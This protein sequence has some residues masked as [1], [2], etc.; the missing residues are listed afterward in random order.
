MTGPEL[1][2]GNR[3][4]ADGRTPVVVLGWVLVGLVLAAAVLFGA[5]GEIPL[6]FGGVRADVRSLFTG[7]VLAVSGAILLLAPPHR[8]PGPLWLLVGLAFP[9]WLTFQLVPWPAGLTA[10]LSPERAAWAERFVAGPL[11]GCAGP[12]LGDGTAATVPLS[13]DPFATREFLLLVLAGILAFFAARAVF[14][15]T[16]TRWLAL[17]TVV[18]LFAAAEAVYGLT[19]WVSGTPK[20]LWRV[21]TAYL[22]TATGTLINRNHF[23]MLLYLGLGASLTLLGRLRDDPRAERRAGA[24][25][26][27]LALRITLAMLIAAQL[28]GIVASKSRAGLAGAVLVLA[29]T[30]VAHLRRGAQVRALDIAIVLALLIPA[31]IV[32]GPTLV[33]RL[34]RVPQEWTSD[35]GRGEVLRTSVGI[36]SDFPLFGT[37]GGTFDL[38]WPLYRPP[39]IH[40]DY[41]YAHSDYLQIV[42]EAG[43]L[44]L[45]LALAPVVLLGLQ[46]T[47]AW[48]RRR[49][50]APDALPWPLIGA[51]LAVLGHEIADFGLQIPSNALL[52]ALLAGSA[53]PL[54]RPRPRSAP[55][56]RRAA[57]VVGAGALL[58]ALPAMAH[59]VARW[60]GL[61]GIVPWP[62]PATVHHRLAYEHFSEWRSAR[63]EGP[64]APLCASLAAEARAQELRPIS[65]RYAVSFATRAAA[66]VEVGAVAD[67][68]VTAVRASIRHA[69]ARA[70]A[71]DPWNGRNRQRL[72][73]TALFLGDLEQALADA[74]VVAAV[75]TLSRRL[76]DELLD[77]GLPPELVAQA[78]ATEPRSFATLLRRLLEQ[79][80]A[81]TLT[82]LVSVEPP[83]DEV[84]CWAAG[85][86]RAVLE[87]YH[88]RP[89]EPFLKACLAQ[90]G[91]GEDE[92]LAQRLRAVLARQMLDEQRIDEAETLVAAMQPEGAAEWLGVGIAEARGDWARVI[93]LTRAI[94]RRQAHQLPPRSLA[95]LYERMGRAYAEQ[96]EVVHALR[97]F[98]RVLEHDP[99]NE[100]AA[101]HVRQLERGINPFYG[102]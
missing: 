79:R 76:I 69:S 73:R 70:R 63:E 21:K 27:G 7:L 23:A 34:E 29:V 36:V 17:L 57:A 43:A 82:L 100:R 98:E 53:A 64:V 19:Q 50:R 54:P 93:E 13:V 47:G 58:L 85:P 30:G 59:S 91:P 5:V 67:A 77:M 84:H 60:P 80:D 26:R 1:G 15:A 55:L 16:R 48:R 52:L 89:A 83:V 66:A 101:R 20:V 88:E 87:R 38:I 71:L 68:Q 8:R 74:R 4:Q 78:V 97:Q 3:D 39:T 62:H 42:L 25:G 46:W 81:A 94:L 12:L 14:G 2:S 56:R 33:E 24:T 35:A 92:E 10:W 32:T 75:P 72:L 45:L 11:A 49:G 40:G 90:F 86:V 37:G 9:T 6:P 22:D 44:G 51:F 102:S 41:N 18:A 65:A 96:G 99:G 28:A 31:L 61:E 95:R